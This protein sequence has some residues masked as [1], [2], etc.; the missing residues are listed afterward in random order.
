MTDN[1]NKQTSDAPAKGKMGV[2]LVLMG[3][4]AIVLIASA[5][6]IWS[7][8]FTPAQ[9]S[10]QSTASIG[11]PVLGN[12]NAPV[13]MIEYSDFQCPFCGKF[14]RDTAP[15]L[16][17]K[18]V[19]T[20][21]LKMEWR[22]FPYFGD[23][24]VQAAVAARAAQ[25]QGKFWEYHDILYHNQGRMNSGAFSDDKLRQYAQQAG[26]DMQKFDA[27][28]SQGKYK[29]AVMRDFKEGQQLGVTGTPTFI[30]NGKSLVGAQPVEVFEKAIE[31][32]AKESTQK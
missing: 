23:E 18:Y 16:V 28:F 22:D 20:G 10:Q 1:Q 15:Q 7:G 2:W 9:Q 6:A 4:G 32:A 19:D 29:E 13:T 21:V 25:E 3:V 12:P 11:N 5:A 31:A 30:I 26:L 17:K 27:S 24:S 14:A 8:G